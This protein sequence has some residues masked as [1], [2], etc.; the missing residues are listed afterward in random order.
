[1]QFC[2]PWVAGTGKSVTSA[3]VASRTGL[4]H[5][6]VGTVAKDNNFYEGWDEQYQCPIVDEDKVRLVVFE[7]SGDV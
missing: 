2:I 1:M 5:V 4:R 3:E 6:D 7:P